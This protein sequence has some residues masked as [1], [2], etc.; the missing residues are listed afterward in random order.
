MIGRQ[1][2]LERR[3]L[4]RDTTESLKELPIRRPAN[5]PPSSS[6]LQ[7]E[8]VDFD[9]Y[10]VR[11]GHR[12]LGYIDVVGAVYV[13]LAGARHDRAEEILQTLVFDEAISALRPIVN[14]DEDSQREG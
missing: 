2:E 14:A 6:D 4:R 12:A 13:V 8:R 11:D 7:W 9:R 3:S 1:G 10:E 5:P